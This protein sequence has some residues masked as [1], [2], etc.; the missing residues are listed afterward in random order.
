LATGR[1]EPE[2]YIGYVFLFF[3]GLERR[4]FV[5]GSKGIVC[6]KERV[7]I[8]NEVKRLLKI[9]NNRSFRGYATNFLG[10][11]WVLYQNDKPIPDYINFDDRYCEKPFH[12]LLAKYVAAGKPIPTNIAIQWLNLHPEFRLRTPARRCSKEFR[13][14]FFRRYK[15]KY[16]DGLVIK[17]NKTRLNIDSSFAP[18]KWCKAS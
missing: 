3:Y 11:E 9:Y 10:M 4:L 13:N 5:D 18:L 14:L 17:P 12:L 16:G 1:S 15:I 6:E 7:A 2:T 8:V